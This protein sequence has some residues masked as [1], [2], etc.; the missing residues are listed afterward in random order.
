MADLVNLTI[1]GRQIQVPAG[2]MVIDAA[3]TKAI[4]VPAFC[5]Y[6]GLSLAAACRL[7]LVEVEQCPQLQ[8]ACTLPVAEGIVVRT[9]TPVVAQARTSMLELLL[10]NHPPACPVCD[11]GG[12]CEL[13]DM[14]FTY[15]AGQS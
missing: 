12:E 15:G 6:E 2:T 5:D 10:T 11:K 7:C 3:K 4:E 13:Q 8:T 14:V 1:D 9:A